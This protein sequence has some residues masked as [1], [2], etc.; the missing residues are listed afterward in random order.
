MRT[1]YFD[2]RINHA[3][4]AN[5]VTEFNEKSGINVVRTEKK[6]K[7]GEEI[8]LNYFPKKNPMKSLRER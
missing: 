1:L 3:C 2:F 5:S 8:T 6:I 7:K 4:N